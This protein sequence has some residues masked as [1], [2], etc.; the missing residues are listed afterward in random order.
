MTE[1]QLAEEEKSYY[2]QYGE[3]DIFWSDLFEEVHHDIKLGMNCRLLLKPDQLAEEHG[4]QG[5]WYYQIECDRK[6]V[7]TGE[8]GVGR[9]GKV[10]LSPTMSR[11]ELC[12]IVL[13]LYIG[14]WQHEAR[15]HYWYKGRQVYG[16]HIDVEAHWE[17]SERTEH[18]GQQ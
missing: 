10:Y 2:G 12:Q 17:I 3:T 16:P 7:V 4:L 8:M 5:R 9:S 18:R 11:T 1:Q 14:Y 15:E 6:D 13:G